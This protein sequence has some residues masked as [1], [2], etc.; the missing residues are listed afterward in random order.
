MLLILIAAFLLF[1]GAGIYKY[2][3]LAR[4]LEEVRSLSSEVA[5]ASDQMYKTIAT[6]LYHRFKKEAEPPA[7]SSFM[8]S[9]PY[10]FEYFL[11]D[12]LEGIYGGEAFVTQ[13]SGDFGVE[14]E[15]ARANGQLYLVHALCQPEDAGVEA[16]AVIHSQAVRQEAKGVVVS[17]SGYTQEALDYAR[18]TGIELIDGVQLARYWSLYL[19]KKERQLADTSR[20]EAGFMPAVT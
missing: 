13:D 19:K 4:E 16:V 15:H 7:G 2:Y 18:E 5:E 12:L 1:T 3:T 6:G 10:E 14:L 17:A 9:S 8:K 20:E 11:S